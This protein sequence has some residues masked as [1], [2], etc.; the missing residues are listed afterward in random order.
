MVLGVAVHNSFRIFL[1][2]WASFQVNDAG[3]PQGAG[4]GCWVLLDVNFL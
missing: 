4:C 2:I 1:Y 3:A